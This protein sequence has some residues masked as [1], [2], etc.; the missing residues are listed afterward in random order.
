[1]LLE[2][3]EIR[4]QEFA[5]HSISE[6]TTDARH[7]ENSF[8]RTRPNDTPTPK[9]LTSIHSCPHDSGAIFISKNTTTSTTTTIGIFNL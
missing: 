4:V 2:I 1:M 3:K 6:H 7:L 5:H 8:L 9:I